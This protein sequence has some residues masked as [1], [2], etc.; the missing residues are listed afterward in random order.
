MTRADYERVIGDL[1]ASGA[2]EPE[3]RRF[4]AAYGDDEVYMFEVWDSQEQFEAH[5]ETLFASLQA[6]GFDA[7]AVSVSPLHSERHD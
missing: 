7:G 6:S 1:E 4:H 2:G 5:R 3:G